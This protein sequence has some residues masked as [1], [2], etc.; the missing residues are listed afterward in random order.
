MS[1][2]TVFPDVTIRDAQSPWMV[3]R[4]IR[5]S[6]AGLEKVVF[7]PEQ[8]VAVVVENCVAKFHR[9][10]SM[11]VGNIL[12]YPVVDFDAAYPRTAR[13]GHVNDRDNPFFQHCS[14]LFSQLAP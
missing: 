4:L 11:V 10:V 14:R 9:V 12:V 1:G 2:S 13:A 7:L 3:F 6:E 5:R 8:H